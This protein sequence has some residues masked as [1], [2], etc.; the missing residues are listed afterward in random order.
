MPRARNRLT[1][2]FSVVIEVVMT[3]GAARVV[4][5]VKGNFVLREPKPVKIMSL[6]DVVKGTSVLL[7]GGDSVLLPRLKGMNG[8]LLGNKR[9]IRFRPPRNRLLDRPA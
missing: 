5:V 2:G 8:F 7:E 9:L 4:G 1:M 6:S 3:D